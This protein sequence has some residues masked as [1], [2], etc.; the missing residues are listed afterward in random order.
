MKV[1]GPG[2]RNRSESARVIRN[3]TWEQTSTRFSDDSLTS[4]WNF[5]IRHSVDCPHTHA[6]CRYVQTQTHRRDG[7]RFKSSRGVDWSIITV[8]HVSVSASG[9]GSTQFKFKCLFFSLL[10]GVNLFQSLKPTKPS[11]TLH[12]IKCL[13]SVGTNKQ[14]ENESFFFFYLYLI[15]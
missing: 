5:D 1:S 11:V 6:A 12:M 7:H 3:K 2:L 8:A 9:A 10:L 15:L 13:R 4:A 14:D